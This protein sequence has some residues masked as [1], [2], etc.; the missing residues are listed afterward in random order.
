MAST[1][2]G[3]RSVDELLAFVL[4]GKRPKYLFFWGNQ[5][6]RG[7]GVGSGCLSQWWP[8]EF[9]VDGV[10]HPSAEHYMMAGKAMLFDDRQTAE[11]ICQAPHPRA[12]K[13]LGRRVRGFD[14]QRWAE[15]RFRIVV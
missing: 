12:A 3:V 13:D 9:T 6:P 2:G 7:G 5:P 14:E 8:A 4:A 11:R 10:R 1:I 15:H